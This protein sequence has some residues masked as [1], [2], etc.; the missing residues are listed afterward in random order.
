MSAI[1]TKISE[2]L[3]FFDSLFATFWKSPYILKAD[4]GVSIA[5]T[6]GRYRRQKMGKMHRDPKEAQAEI[7]KIEALRAIGGDAAVAEHFLDERKKSDE[8]KKKTARRENRQFTQVYAEG[9]NR[10]QKL[11]RDEPQA[12]RLYAF[13]AQEMGPD[14]TLCASRATLA[15]ALNINER[16]VSRH[17][18]TLEKLNA[19]IILKLGTANVYCLNPEEVWKSFD[20]AK[21][22]AAFRTKTL[23]GKSENPYV[24]KRLATLLGGK[25]PEQRD[26][27][28]DLPEEDADASESMPSNDWEVGDPDPHFKD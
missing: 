26:M 7:A 17:V 10:L 24:K 3:L 20:N 16:T 23:V 5:D 1:E 9:W 8:A 19:I 6:F 27:F 22:Y 15:E 2:K 12:A 14:A 21:P 18:K 11:I 13:F 25:L 28:S 4:N